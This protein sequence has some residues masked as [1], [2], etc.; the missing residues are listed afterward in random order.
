MHLP[1]EASTALVVK[2]AYCTTY[3]ERIDN[4]GDRERKGEGVG[5]RECFI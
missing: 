5:K 1:T 2:L 4:R 3:L